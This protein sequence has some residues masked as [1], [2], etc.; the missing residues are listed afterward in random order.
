VR[1]NARILADSPRDNGPVSTQTPV[2]TARRRGPGRSFT[3]L[4]WSLVPVLVV[5]V[6][7]V[8][9]Q[10][11]SP[12]PVTSVDPGPDVAYAARISPVPLPAP[13]P[14]PG[15]WRATSSHVDAPA[16]QKRSPVTL[17]IGYLTDENRFAEVVIGDRPVDIL[18]P[19]TAPGATADGTVQV[20]AARWQAYRTQRGERL[21]AATLGKAGVLVTG[22]AS[23]TDLAELA[24]SVR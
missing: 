3:G 6:L 13:G 20:G 12:S 19:A 23:G 18:L 1:G 2:P 16:G 11:G 24:A 22:D 21:L 15:T 10:R 9:W 8:L 17:T 4:L 7:L 14:L 5:I